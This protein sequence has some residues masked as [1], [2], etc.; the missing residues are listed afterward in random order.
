[1]IVHTL[2]GYSKTDQ[3]LSS[4]FQFIRGV[5]SNEDE[6]SHL[7]RII[8]FPICIKCIVIWRKIRASTIFNWCIISKFLVFLYLSSALYPILS[9][10][11]PSDLAH[12]MPPTITKVIITGVATTVHFGSQCIY[13]DF[14]L[15][16]G[17]VQFS[18]VC[19]L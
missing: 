18:F 1:M 15:L 10:S 11:N 7:L 4:P 17:C 3:I 9:S 13:F 2:I 6:G 5:L 12:Q 8:L 16:V 19:D 14:L